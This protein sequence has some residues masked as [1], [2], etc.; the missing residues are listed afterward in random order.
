MYLR[1]GGHLD[2]ASAVALFFVC[3]LVMFTM[4][5]HG[6]AIFVMVTYHSGGSRYIG[7]PVSEASSKRHL[8]LALWKRSL[9]MWLH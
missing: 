9:N 6:I 8:S 4:T 2:G 5:S 7:M 1:S 3:T